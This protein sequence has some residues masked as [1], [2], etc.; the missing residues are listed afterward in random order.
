MLF[1]VSADAGLTLVFCFER[2]AIERMEGSK[3][4]ERMNETSLEGSKEAL[5]ERMK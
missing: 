3:G 5:D 2:G 1:D 4:Y